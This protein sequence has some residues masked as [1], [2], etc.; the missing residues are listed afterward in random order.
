M[1]LLELGQI[2]TNIWCKE[3]ANRDLLRKAAEK[4]RRFMAVLTEVGRTRCD[5]SI[6]CRL[7]NRKDLYD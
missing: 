5:F 7:V 1:T 2:Y 4:Y 3:R 6:F